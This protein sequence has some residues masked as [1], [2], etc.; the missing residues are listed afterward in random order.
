MTDQ[1]QTEIKQEIDRIN[2]EVYFCY[3]M[4]KSYG[5]EDYR[6]SNS[7]TEETLKDFAE[8]VAAKYIA[9]LT[10]AHERLNYHDWQQTD[11]ELIA[12]IGEVIKK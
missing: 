4:G 3:S 5:M 8:F 7:D 9:L 2:D 12:E 10:R 6:F 11:T 1:I